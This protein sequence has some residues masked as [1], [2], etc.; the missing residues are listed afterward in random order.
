[1]D[2]LFTKIIVQC[3]NMHHSQSLAFPNAHVASHPLCLLVGYFCRSGWSSFE[4]N[5]VD[6]NI[7]K[8]YRACHQCVNFAETK[9]HSNKCQDNSV[10]NKENL[11]NPEVFGMRTT[12]PVTTA[13]HFT[14]SCHTEM[15]RWTSRK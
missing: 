9:C 3:G 11:L 14:A 8:N 2:Y 12:L 1:M 5:Q 4:S 6:V 7:G 13:Y 15:M 10:N